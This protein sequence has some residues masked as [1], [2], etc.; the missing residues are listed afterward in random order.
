MPNMR[1]TTRIH[2]MF[3]PE[4]RIAARLGAFVDRLGEAFETPPWTLP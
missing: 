2:A 4:R 3:L 1:M